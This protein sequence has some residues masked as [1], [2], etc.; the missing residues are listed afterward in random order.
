METKRF[1]GEELVEAL[2]SGDLDQPD[3]VA[4]TGMVKP[5][6][7]AGSISFAQRSCKEWVDIPSEMIASAEVVG[8]RN[9][10]DHS[11][12]VVRIQLKQPDTSEGN[13]Y[14]RLLTQS[15]EA[16]AV[17]QLDPNVAMT[18]SPVGSRSRAGRAF[19]HVMPAGMTRANSMAMGALRAGGQVGGGG[20]HCQCLYYGCGTCLDGSVML[21]TDCSGC[22]D[23]I[24]SDVFLPAGPAVAGQFMY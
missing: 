4:L 21:C 11:H 13:A 17:R 24:C 19:S 9:C 7:E 14:R 12:P 3:H 10:E 15:L 18:Q 1:S 22:I 20:G 16:A 23:P 6:E 8:N 2:A 5:A